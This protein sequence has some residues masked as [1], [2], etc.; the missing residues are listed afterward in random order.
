MTRL[1]WNVSLHLLLQHHYVSQVLTVTMR[2]RRRLHPLIMVA[3]VLP[4]SS[5]TPRQS[6]M[7]G[8]LGER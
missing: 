2:L 8:M 3:L 6:L 5:L 4:P 1:P 7:K